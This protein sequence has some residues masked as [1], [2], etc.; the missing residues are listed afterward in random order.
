MNEI[1]VE[2]WNIKDTIAKECKYDFKPLIYKFKRR[3]FINK[4]K[5]LVSDIGRRKRKRPI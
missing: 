2:I 4:I 5:T 3:Q 1:L